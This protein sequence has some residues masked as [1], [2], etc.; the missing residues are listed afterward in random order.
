MVQYNNT[1]LSLKKYS[2]VQYN[3]TSL[4]LEKEIWLPVFEK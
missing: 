3:N 2:M 4:S 1:L